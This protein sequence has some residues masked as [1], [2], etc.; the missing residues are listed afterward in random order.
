MTKKIDKVQYRIEVIRTGDNYIT[1]EYAELSSRSGFMPDNGNPIEHIVLSIV[2]NQ[3]GE[4]KIALDSILKK[5]NEI[6][7]LN[8]IISDYKTASEKILGEDSV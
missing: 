5:D 4:I 7:R 1:K 8:R 3:A 6:R 2:G